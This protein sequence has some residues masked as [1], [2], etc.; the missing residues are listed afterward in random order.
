MTVASALNRKTF[1]GDGVTTSFGTS[2]VVFFETSNLQVYVVNNTTGV[3]TLLVENTGYTVSGGDGST[4]TVNLTG[5]S[6]PH[7]ALLTGTTLV[8]LRALP[9][10][11]TDDLVNNSISDAEVVEERFDRTTMMVQQLAEELDRVVK[12]SPAETGTDALTELPF[13]RASKFLAFDASKNPIAAAGTTEVPVSAFM[14]TLL[15]DTSA[16]AGRATLDAAE[17]VVTTKGDLYVGGASG[18]ES[19]KGV[20]SDA[21]ILVPSSGAADGL[22]WV[23]AGFAMWNGS[24][25]VSVAANAIT[26]AIKTD[27]GAD[28]SDTDPV[29]VAFRDATLTTG[30]YTVI[31]IVAATS[32]TVSSGS[33][34]GTVSGQAHRIYVVGVNDGGTFR[35]GVWNPWNDTLIALRGLD[36]GSRYTSAAEGGAGAADS[37]HVLYTGTAVVDKAVRVLGY[38]ESTQAT[39]GTWASAP[40]KVQVMGPGVMRT[41]DVVQTIRTATGAVATGTT[42]IPNDDTIPQDTEGDPYMSTS[43]TP[44]SASNLLK[45]FANG[46]FAHSAANRLCM[47]LFKDGSANAVATTFFDNAANAGQTLPINYQNVSGGVAGTAFRIRAGSAAAGTTTMN[48]SSGTRRYGGTMNSILEV[49]EVF[50]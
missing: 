7:G 47:A 9:Y 28:P 24:L 48:G 10:T 3:E 43:I 8:I 38:F 6:S 37:P 35:L 13:D 1:A 5:G 26:V 46:V 29:F 32:V 34:L 22:A 25:A 12:L 4:G 44:T 23:G 19:R 16:T 30:T 33:T 45:V 41:G 39:A 17:S 15:D 49:T 14:A 42:V 36:D 18:A 31:K 2:P 11:Q 40:S 20:G 50:V 27:A 21:D